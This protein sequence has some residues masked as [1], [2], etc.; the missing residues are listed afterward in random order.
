MLDPSSDDI[1]IGGTTGKLK[2]R[3]NP[4]LKNRFALKRPG[5]LMG[6]PSWYYAQSNNYWPYSQYYSSWDPYW[7]RNGL[8]ESHPYLSQ[9]SPESSLAHHYGYQSLDEL[10]QGG[11]YY[12]SSQLASTRYPFPSRPI[13]SP[14]SDENTS[15]PQRCLCEDQIVDMSRERSRCCQGSTCPSSWSNRQLSPVTVNTSQELTKPLFYSPTLVRS[16]YS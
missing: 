2:R 9:F 16:R 14:R 10:T 4:N 15:H 12:P 3:T 7:S 6:V 11:E 5:G 8:Q 1:I 13:S